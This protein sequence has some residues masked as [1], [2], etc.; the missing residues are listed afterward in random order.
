MRTRNISAPLKTAETCIK[1][2]RTLERH[3]VT[4]S[5]SISYRVWVASSAIRWSYCWVS[6]IHFSHNLLHVPFTTTTTG[7]KAFSFAATIVWNSIPLSIRQT[8][9]YW[10]LQTSSQNS[11]IYHP[12]LVHFPTQRHQRLRLERAWICA[13][14]KFCNN[15][16]NNNNN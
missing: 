8:T 5:N 13:L 16:N 3:S 6:S 12:R 14:Y 4:A 1:Y 9:I 2:C 15:N 11:F 7:R 10:L